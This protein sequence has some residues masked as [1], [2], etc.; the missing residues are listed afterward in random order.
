MQVR[1]VLYADEGTVLTNG[2]DY[3]NIIWLADGV[4]PDSYHPIPRA[5]YD[6]I[7]AEMEN[8]SADS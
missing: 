6:A 4:S 7:M 3:G 1:T 2:K 5:E 8:S